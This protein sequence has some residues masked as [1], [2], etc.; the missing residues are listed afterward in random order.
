MYILIIIMT[1]STLGVGKTRDIPVTS[2]TAEF[3]SKERCIVAS[4]AVMNSL[5]P[6]YTRIW[7][8]LCIAK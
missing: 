7:S 3:S 4:K 1:T 2:L 8:N 6:A 5:P